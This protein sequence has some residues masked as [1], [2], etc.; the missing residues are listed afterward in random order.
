MAHSSSSNSN[1]S[2]QGGGVTNERDNTSRAG[3][4]PGDTAG[5][6]ADRTQRD[7]RDSKARPDSNKPKQKVIPLADG[8]FLTPDGSVITRSQA[9]A[10]GYD[11]PAT[12]VDPES[13]EGRRAA[14]INRRARSNRLGS[15][16]TILTSPG[17]SL[18][19]SNVQ[20]SGLQSR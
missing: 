6:N 18:G 16:Q 9:E 20:R 3:L 2:H 4:G 19:A 1:A 12:R 17:G 8:R 7:G 10:Q 14:E 11:I 15:S 13:P 5:V